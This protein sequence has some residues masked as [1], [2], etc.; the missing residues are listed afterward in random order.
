MKHKPE[1]GGQSQ[2]ELL[3]LLNAYRQAVDESIISSM[4]DTKG[5]I[6]YANKKF[7]EVTKYSEK[8]LVGEN[9]RIVNSDYHTKKFF[10]DMWKTISNGNVWHNEIMN[11]AK[12]GTLYWVD[13]VILP[14]KD[15]K[16]KVIQY[17]SLR[18]LINDKKQREAERKEYI[19]SL[20]DML[21]MTNHEVRQPVANCLGLMNIIDSENPSK[22]DLV[23]IYDHIKDSASKLEVFTRKLTLFLHDLTEK[24]KKQ[25]EN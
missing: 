8:E 18:M 11:K 9:H 7:C 5:T 3:Q 2:K 10:K 13:T 14:V 4:T 21:F 15:D 16:G 22:K 23:K 24:H 20:E 12:D 17:L 25:N 6:I 1:I 19:K